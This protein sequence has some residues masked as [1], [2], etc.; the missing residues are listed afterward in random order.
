VFCDTLVFIADF[1]LLCYSMRI[2][3]MSPSPRQGILKGEL[4]K[5]TP[6]FSGSA[7]IGQDKVF[8]KRFLQ[9]IPAIDHAVFQENIIH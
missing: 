7:K 6:L 9:N 4:N 8:P 1:Q 2:H 3:Y 5:K